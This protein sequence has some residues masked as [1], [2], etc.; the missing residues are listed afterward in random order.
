MQTHLI[1]IV[2]DVAVTEPEENWGDWAYRNVKENGWKA[3]G[4][5]IIA[6]PIVPTAVGATLVGAGLVSGVQNGVAWLRGSDTI[7]KVELGK[8]GALHDEQGQSVQVEK[9]YAVH[10]DEAR[11]NLVILASEFYN[12]IVAEQIADL[13]AFIRGAVRAESIKIEVVSEKAGEGGFLSNLGFGVKAKGGV[14]KQHSVEL[15]YDEPEVVPLAEPP[16]WLRLFPEIK[17][18]VRAAQKGTMKRSMSVDTTFGMTASTAKQ[19]GI[20]VSWL[21][22][23][24]FDIEAKFV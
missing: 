21:G 23:Q 13:V 18:S 9:T 5:A 12:V 20:D 10:P 7:E 22:R 4:A 14:T 19:A 6:A 2:A 17:A 3:A 11:S 16:F 15:H 24:R 8:A 1:E